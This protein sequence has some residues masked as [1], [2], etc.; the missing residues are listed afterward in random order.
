MRLNGIL[1]SRLLIF[2]STMLSLYT[3]AQYVIVPGLSSLWQLRYVL[4][5]EPVQCLCQQVWALKK[6]TE[7]AESRHSGE[8]LL[9][10]NVGTLAW[11]HRG[12]KYHPRITSVARRC[13]HFCSSSSFWASRASVCF[14]VGP[15][16]LLAFNSL[17]LPACQLLGNGLSSPFL[18]HL[19]LHFPPGPPTSHFTLLGVSVIEFSVPANLSWQRGHLTNKILGVSAAPWGNVVN[20]VLE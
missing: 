11:T 9:I 3:T 17:S 1:S 16:S 8:I 5:C 15:S 12:T 10:V 19:S 20:K 18:T 7:A 4:P 6:R 13:Y 14:S 2:L